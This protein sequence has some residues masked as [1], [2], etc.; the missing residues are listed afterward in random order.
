MVPSSI[1]V[2]TLAALLV[3][4]CGVRCTDWRSNQP[5]VN[6]NRFVVP[7]HPVLHLSAQA[8]QRLEPSGKRHAAWRSFI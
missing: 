5:A 6:L 2:L 7:P 4:R 8:R 1:C 3:T